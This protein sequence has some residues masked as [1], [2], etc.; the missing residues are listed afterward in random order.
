MSHGRAATIVAAFC[1]TFVPVRTVL[2]AHFHCRGTPPP[3]Q[4][5]TMLSWGFPSVSDSPSSAKTFKRSAGRP[6]GPTALRFAT[7]RIAPSSLYLVGTSSSD[8]HGGHVLSSPTM[9]GSGVGDLVLSILLNYTQRSCAYT[10]GSVRVS[11]LAV[12]TVRAPSSVLYFLHQV[13][14]VIAAHLE[15]GN[16]KRTRSATVKLHLFSV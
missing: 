7:A 10:A 2:F 11:H 12:V 1:P 9:A 15:A 6:S 3:L 4:K 13:H 8:L 14:A 16:R 5:A